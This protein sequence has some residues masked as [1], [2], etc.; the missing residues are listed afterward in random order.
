MHEKTRALLEAL[1]NVAEW[2][3]RPQPKPPEPAWGMTLRHWLEAGC[4]DL[5]PPSREGKVKVVVVRGRVDENGDSIALG[6]EDEGPDWDEI[7]AERRERY[8]ATGRARARFEA[9]LWVTKPVV[10]QVEDVEVEG[11]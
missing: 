2:D 6:W 1:R 4:P 10:E 7:E 11:G 3:A 5:E 8:C 9:T